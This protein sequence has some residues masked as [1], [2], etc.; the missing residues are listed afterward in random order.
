MTNQYFNKNNQI[1]MIHDQ[2]QRILHILSL[3][4]VFDNMYFSVTLK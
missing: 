4:Y 3:M 2:I 1:E